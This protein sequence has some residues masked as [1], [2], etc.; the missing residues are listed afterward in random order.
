MNSQRGSFLSSD[1]AGFF[2]FPPLAIG[3]MD[4]MRIVS[5]RDH[6]MAVSFCPLGAGAHPN[7]PSVLR[8]SS[9]FAVVFRGNPLR[10][11]LSDS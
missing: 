11:Y 9:L 4:G 2:F 7:F 8:L 6:R 1:R 5:F 10:A 3:Y